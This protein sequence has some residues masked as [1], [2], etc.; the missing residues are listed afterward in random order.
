MRAR[1]H[2]ALNEFKGRVPTLSSLGSNGREKNARSQEC[3]I[4]QFSK[5]R[6]GWR[7]GVHTFQSSR[8]RSPLVWLMTQSVLGPAFA[9]ISAPSLGLGGGGGGPF[10]IR[11]GGAVGFFGAP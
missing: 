5:G 1:I 7:A 8:S 9:G 4:V 10:P 3:G 6:G 11:L 2:D